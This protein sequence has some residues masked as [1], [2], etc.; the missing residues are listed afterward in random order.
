MEPWTS[1]SRAQ[2]SQLSIALS[3]TGLESSRCTHVETNV[4]WTDY[5]SPSLCACLKVPFAHLQYFNPSG[6]RSKWPRILVII[7][8]S[9]TKIQAWFWSV[10]SHCHTYERESMHPNRKKVC[11]SSESFVWGNNLTKQVGGRGVFGAI[12]IVRASSVSLL[13]NTFAPKY[14]V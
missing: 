13:F 10:K 2:G 1:T 14:L 5:R 6:L 9:H 3:R 7:C 11:S 8:I 4:A 12:F